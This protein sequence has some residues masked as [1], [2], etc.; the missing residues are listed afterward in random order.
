[1][2]ASP[3]TG[4]FVQEPKRDKG[5]YARDPP[6]EVPSKHVRIV[7]QEEER[8][9]AQLVEIL[10]RKCAKLRQKVEEESHQRRTAQEQLTT[11]TAEL[12]VLQV[13][14][15]EKERQIADLCHA[16]R[17]FSEDRRKAV[18]SNLALGS[19]EQELQQA[20]ATLR[21][22]EQDLQN[23]RASGARTEGEW[24]EQILKLVTESQ[25]DKEQCKHLQEELQKSKA[26]CAHLT[27]KAQ[28]LI[29]RYE[30][31]SAQR[32]QLESRCISLEEKLRAR[33][34]KSRDEVGS[35]QTKVKQSLQARQCAEEIA[36]GHEEKYHAVCQRADEAEMRSKL[37]EEELQ[38]Q[39]SLCAERGRRLSALES[40]LDQMNSGHQQVMRQVSRA[41]VPTPSSGQRS[42]SRP[43]TSASLAS[44][45]TTTS[46][47]GATPSGDISG[48]LRGGGGSSRSGTLQPQL[49]SSQNRG[50]FSEEP[51]STQTKLPPG[52]IRRAGSIPI[53]RVA[54]R[55]PASRSAQQIP[56]RPSSGASGACKQT[57]N[58]RNHNA[59]AIAD[60]GIE[61]V[62][63]PDSDDSSDSEILSPMHVCN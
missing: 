28:E 49:R 23:L 19:K 14:L 31:E 12:E 30:D 2:G 46:A 11:K 54:V 29:Q 1:M 16:Q 43:G 40:Q 48:Q 27:E 59:D 58:P 45:G 32:L 35:A 44:V 6:T 8:V 50:S 17:E 41:P 3:G 36:R 21:K 10:E 15:E 7:E 37:L 26:Q 63:P 42:S 39:K 53:R 60:P 25:S 34:H 61:A 4:L 9:N 5:R 55:S 51:P 62:F 22:C 33:D 56:A 24:K 20:R 18:Q 52:A 13:Q 38:K 47:P 57:V